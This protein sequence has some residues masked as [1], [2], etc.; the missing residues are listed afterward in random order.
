VNLVLAWGVLRFAFRGSF[1]EEVLVHVPTPLSDARLARLASWGMGLMLIIISVKIASAAIAAPIEIPLWLVAAGAA[2]PVLLGSPRRY[3]LIANIDWPTL[4]FFVA[5][6]VL[7]RAVFDSGAVQS[8]LAA[9]R[10]WFT[11]IPRLLVSGALLSQLVSNVP[12]VALA[13]PFM[14]APATSPE[15]FLALSAGSTIAGNLTLVGAASNVIIVQA[16]ERRGGPHI[17]FWHFFA[18][19]A[20]LAILNLVVYWVFLAVI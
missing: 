16:A 18:V 14:Q 2:A 15:A 17:D 6:F 5:L 7:V 11:D 8:W 9:D 10:T 12:L 3:S 13:L 1:H 4:I 20:P 19:G